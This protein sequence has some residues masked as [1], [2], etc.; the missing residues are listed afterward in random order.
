M[1]LTK[2]YQIVKPFYKIVLTNKIS[3]QSIGDLQYLMYMYLYNITTIINPRYSYYDDSGLIP[4][5][6]NYEYFKEKYETSS[7]E[8]LNAL[9]HYGFYLIGKLIFSNTIEIKNKPDEVVKIILGFTP[10][11]E[12]IYKSYY[13]LDFSLFLNELALL[14]YEKRNLTFQ[15]FECEA[16]YSNPNQESNGGPGPF[17]V[18]VNGTSDEYL[19]KVREP[20]KY[21]LLQVPTGVVK[22]ADGFPIIDKNIPTSYRNQT[23]KGIQYGWLSG[24]WVNNETKNTLPSV[25][26]A[27]IDN[28]TE[29]NIQINKMLNLYKKLGDKE[30][31]IS[32][33]FNNNLTGCLPTNGVLS[34]TS[35]FFNLK[36]NI[37]LYD[38]PSYLFATVSIVIDADIIAWENKRE[39]FTTRPVCAIRTFKSNEAIQTWYPY[40]GTV[41]T[42]GNKFQPYQELTFVTPPHAEFLAG[43][44]TAFPAVA[45][46]FT[47]L[48]G[49]NFYDP[50]YEYE[51]DTPEWI[52][53]A[54]A[55]QNKFIFGQYVVQSQSSIIE[56]G[57]T[58]KNPV[59]LTFNTVKDWGKQ[60]ALSRFYGGIHWESTNK[61]SVEI[62]NIVSEESYKKLL[63]HNII[64][65]H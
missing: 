21:N 25:D 18:D 53:P 37:S 14:S 34:L 17:P 59:V 19:S 56:P 27:T 63:E 51:F 23:F 43:H 29:L 42:S 33:F 49:S 8:Y 64:A 10:E 61:A 46:L 7:E 47:K 22:N 39:K 26:Y 41:L 52:Y 24:F 57:L 15:I 36:N 5:P 13:T 60:C 35:F 45:N 40:K 20:L 54:L 30:K 6:V 44:S 32:E 28:Q 62:G 38:E 4:K 2:F 11:I 48:Y 65:N 9:L 58:P 12:A 55:G 1:I 16:C 3:S 31:I 50:F